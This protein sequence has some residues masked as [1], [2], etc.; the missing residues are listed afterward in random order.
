MGHCCRLLLL[1]VAQN[2]ILNCDSL[3][4]QEFKALSYSKL[5]QLYAK[6]YDGYTKF[7]AEY[8]QGVKDDRPEPHRLLAYAKNLEEIKKHNELYKQGKSSFMLGLTVMSDTS[9]ED[10]DD[11]FPVV[12]FNE[13]DNPVPPNLTE[14]SIKEVNWVAKNYVTP[15]KNLFSYVD[16]IPTITTASTVS[17]VVEAVVKSRTQRLIK[18]SIQEL[19]DCGGVACN[20]H[21]RFHQYANYIMR[22]RGMV[23]ERK[24]PM[25][26]RQQSCGARGRRYGRVKTFLTTVHGEK[27][28]FKGLLAKRPIATR[29]LLTQKFHNYKGGIFRD[30]L[31]SP[32]NVFSHTVLA[33]GFTEDYILL[34]NSWGTKWGE[35]GYM[36]I[37]TDPKENCNLYLE[38]FGAL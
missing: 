18:L 25:F 32:N 15:V 16:C 38:S 22:N 9:K 2:F 8:K 28:L 12:V 19:L 1:L 37:S 29:I 17:D 27:L 35:N 30:C 10:L 6:H 7:V 26:N 21:V 3:I 31:Q 24:Y 14:S 13:T 11:L 33:V 36:R 23:S 5:R 34:K 4:H 20:E